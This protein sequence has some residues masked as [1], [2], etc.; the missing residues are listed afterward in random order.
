ML[1][2]REEGDGE[3]TIKEENEDEDD[4]DDEADFR[5]GGGGGAGEGDG[6]LGQNL[7]PP[8]MSPRRPS[9]RKRNSIFGR[10]G[11]WGSRRKSLLPTT[12]QAGGHENDLVEASIPPILRNARSRSLSQS[13]MSRSVSAIDEG[14]ANGAPM[15]SPSLAKSGGRPGRGR[16]SSDLDSEDAMGHDRRASTS[17]NSSHERDV[18]WPRSRRVQ[19]LGL[20]EMD[21]GDIPDFPPSPELD[22]EREEEQEEDKQRPVYVWTGSGDHAT[23]MRIGFKKRISAV[24]L[25][26]YA[27]K[28]YVELNLTAFEKILKK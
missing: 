28:Q 4:D 7:N 24:W 6:L 26:A 8:K 15:V 25:E 18:F 16:R 5:D 21:S 17:S 3:E 9:N 12:G 20:V 11:G 27:L 23:V 13:G 1:E 22:G 19:G 10:L 2:E 14:S